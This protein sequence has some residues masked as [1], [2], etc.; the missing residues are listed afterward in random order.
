MAG[1]AGFLAVEDEEEVERPTVG[2]EAEGK[3]K[4]AVKAKGQRK[5][6]TSGLR[7]LLLVE[8]HLVFFHHFL[9]ERE[10]QQCGR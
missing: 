3:G 9:R 7:W 5:K 2:D 4:L 10:S 8:L 6:R 1:A